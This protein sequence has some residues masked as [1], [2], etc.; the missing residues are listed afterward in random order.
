MNK[1]YQTFHK[2]NTKAINYTLNTNHQSN[3]SRRT[4][5]AI[6]SNNRKLDNVSILLFYKHL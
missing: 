2:L 5:T 3:T 6:N 1:Y 4:I